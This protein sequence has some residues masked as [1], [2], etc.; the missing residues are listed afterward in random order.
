[1]VY[2]A[3]SGSFLGFHYDDSSPGCQGC[4]RNGFQSRVPVAD[5]VRERWNASASAGPETGGTVVYITAVGLAA[6]V[7]AA[8]DGDGTEGA[9][10]RFVGVD[11]TPGAV[12]VGPGNVHRYSTPSGGPGSGGSVNGDGGRSID[13]MSA[14]N[15]PP[16]TGTFY[17]QA[18]L[19]C[20][21]SCALA[22]PRKTPL[23]GGFYG[24]DGLLPGLGV[25]G[26]ASF[27]T[28]TDGV[29]SF[30]GLAGDIAPG[31]V[32]EGVG[33]AMT[34]RYY[35]EARYYANL[36]REEEAW[37]AGEP[38]RGGRERNGGAFIGTRRENPRESRAS[39][40]PPLPPLPRPPAGGSLYGLTGLGEIATTPRK[41][42]PPPPPPQPP[43]PHREASRRAAVSALYGLDVRGL[44]PPSFVPSDP[45]PP[46]AETFYGLEQRRETSTDLPPP[47]TFSRSVAAEWLDYTRIKCVSPPW[48]TPDGDWAEAGARA[49]RRCVVTVT[50]NGDE[51]DDVVA[52][53]GDGG[54]F[55][56]EEAMPNAALVPFTY[57]P[58]VPVVVSVVSNHAAPPALGYGA[59][60]PFDG[61]TEITVRGTGF[62][63]SAH[64]SC[65]FVD[66]SSGLP[67]M[68]VP[69]A[70]VDDT[71][72]TCVTPRRAPRLKT[73]GSRGAAV[74]SRE[75]ESPAGRVEPAQGNPRRTIVEPSTRASAADTSDAGPELGE[76]DTWRAAGTIP[77]GGDASVNG[78]SVYAAADLATLAPCFVADVALSNDGVRYSARHPGAVFLYCDVYV[79]PGRSD[80]GVAAGTPD[81]PFPNI[82]SALDAALRGAR[83]RDKD[84]EARFEGEARARGIG[85]GGGGDVTSTGGPS[86]GLAR[87][88]RPRP[89]HAS[90]G[91]RSFGARSKLGWDAA[92]GGGYEGKA[93][94]WINR[95]V[96]RLS[97]GAYG[98]EGNVLLHVDRQLLEMVAG[99]D[100]GFDGGREGGFR[101][102]AGRSDGGVGAGS[103]RATVDCREAG[104]G[105]RGGGF[106]N[107]LFASQRVQLGGV[108]SAGADGRIIGSGTVSF[109]RIDT[110]GCYA[111]GGREALTN[112]G[113]YADGR[114]GFAGSSGCRGDD[115]FI[116]PGHGVPN[117]MGGLARDPAEWEAFDYDDEPVNDG[118]SWYDY[119]YE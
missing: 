46:F 68:E 24:L 62:L 49:V 76:R 103:G 87:G 109:T 19:A 38:T 21:F 41:P 67:A 17:P 83:V 51:F 47:A 69:A 4:N 36:R 93:G 78:E 1:M 43:S 89:G 64:L 12:G 104:S 35:D 79:S 101:G 39:F 114:G 86:M 40:P 57:D 116:H 81:R 108:P 91:L 7:R 100:D 66:F 117:A 33:L 56:E 42:P 6:N 107:P 112:A 105:A 55:L 115:H 73:R 13:P 8:G 111:D 25:E 20:L 94:S 88:A 52:G 32:D 28:A 29:G 84:G 75:R 119:D 77:D 63:Q 30:V 48:P 98:G 74:A 26:G 15:G 5:R 27:G 85:G 102:G 96:V 37:A 18:N 10:P 31:T 65:R 72:A 97:P 11:R 59:R 3:G 90:T 14:G 95:D 22:P 54:G 45:P 44:E 23:L 58:R 16:V 60:G 110:I 80:P 34:G 82:Q 92:A 2:V 113:C 50:N 53:G 9:P 118:G 71:T 61:A 70:W 106:T 99:D